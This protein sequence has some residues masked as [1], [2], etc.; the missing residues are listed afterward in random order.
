M[1]LLDVVRE[2]CIEQGFK[3]TYW[4]AYSGGMDSHVMLSLFAALRREY[5]LKL[6]AIHIHHGISQHASAWAAHCAAV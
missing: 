1:T 4:L 3:K 2:F 5:P 6:R